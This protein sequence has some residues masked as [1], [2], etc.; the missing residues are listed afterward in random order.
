MY[1]ADYLCTWTCK[2]FVSCI[3]TI[4]I[5]YYPIN[6]HLWW[7]VLFSFPTFYGVNPN[8]ICV[9]TL[10]GTNNNNNICSVNLCGEYCVCIERLF[11][12]HTIWYHTMGV[13][14]ELENGVFGSIVREL[15]ACHEFKLCIGLE[16]RIVYELAFKSFWIILKRTS[17]N[18]EV[19]D[20]GSTRQLDFR[21]TIHGR[22]QC[23]NENVN[24]I[25]R[26]GYWQS[27]FPKTPSNSDIS[28]VSLCGEDKLDNPKNSLSNEK[29]K[30]D[31]VVRYYK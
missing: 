29:I 24:W 1:Q 19:K 10:Y 23:Q 27:M 7:T 9:Y 16:F 18:I 28:I 5:L 8:H 21:S 20:R 30:A 14:Y 17:G 12:I 13:G 15:S 6:I 31:T 11:P 4:Q 2:C 25:N 22:E 3:L 26:I